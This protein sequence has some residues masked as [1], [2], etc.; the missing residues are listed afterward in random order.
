[1]KALR[2]D[3]K[4]EKDPY[5]RS[6]LIVMYKEVYGEAFRA[7]EAERPMRFARSF[8]RSCFTYVVLA[9]L[10]L[11][12]LGHFVGFW[13][14]LTIVL[15]MLG[16]ITVLAAFALRSVDRLSESG[17]KTTITSG[18][19]FVRLAFGARSQSEMLPPSTDDGRPTSNPG[20]LP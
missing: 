16:I 11:C 1:M 17:M 8:I 7:D 6:Q 10:L 4:I 15:A 18:L 19:Q 5:T 14:V 9:T 12:A 2:G 3:I 13:I 20:Q